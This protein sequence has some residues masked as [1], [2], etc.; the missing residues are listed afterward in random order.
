MIP[1]TPRRWRA[2]VVAALHGLAWWLPRRCTNPA[3]AA[4]AAIVG[5][6]VLLLD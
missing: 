6:V 3:V 4:A 5:A 1:P 2:L